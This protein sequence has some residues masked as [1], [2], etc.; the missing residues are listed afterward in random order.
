MG[1]YRYS[2]VGRLQRA[3]CAYYRNSEVTYRLCP[4][5][6]YRIPQ[7][8]LITRELVTCSHS[9]LY[10][11]DQTQ[12]PNNCAD[13]ASA[14]IKTPISASFEKHI[15][16]A[17]YERSHYQRA[18]KK[19]IS[20]LYVPR[21]RCNE[22]FSTLVPYMNYDFLEDAAALSEELQLR[23]GAT[24]DCNSP[25]HLMQLRQ[26]WHQFQHLKANTDVIDAKILKVT[27][28]LKI[29]KKGKAENKPTVPEVVEGINIHDA[30]KDELLLLL[31]KLTYIRKTAVLPLQLFE[32]EL[33]PELLG[34]PNTLSPNT[35]KYT[36]KVERFFSPPLFSFP[37]RSHVQ[38]GY[39]TKG[40]ELSP[41]SLG[42][43]YLHGRLAEVE[44][45]LQD[46]VADTLDVH[47]YLQQ[48][49]P[50]FAKGVSIEGC[51]ME[52]KDTTQKTSTLRLVRN[53]AEEDIA[54]L[55][56]V[57]G[58]SLPSYV[59]YF[60]KKK[61]TN[62]SKFLPQKLYSVGRLYNPPRTFYSSNDEV[63]EMPNTSDIKNVDTKSEIGA[64]G[65]F[66][67]MQTSSVSCFILND[68]ENPITESSIVQEVLRIVRS[69]YDGLELHYRLV[70][71]RAGLLKPH[72]KQAISIQ[73]LT[74]TDVLMTSHQRSNSNN[75]IASDGK[76]TSDII[77]CSK[78]S[79]DEVSDMSGCSIDS[80]E[81][82]YVEVGR[83]SVCGDYISKRLLMTYVKN[84]P[85]VQVEEHN[86][87]ECVYCEV[88]NV[89]K[90][91]AV[92]LEN[93]QTHSGSYSLPNVIEKR[94]VAR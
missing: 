69:I 20:S 49:N 21:H 65:I 55:F 29:L 44:L 91:L 88:L 93:L 14:N 28:R 26:Q 81:A 6:I 37:P 63:A 82:G 54:P 53:S 12:S 85:Q 48:V 36:C 94:M 1:V 73:M 40:L 42:S 74:T 67:S 22:M 56:L 75:S 90:F 32:D 41:T 68:K 9:L 23:D 64:A 33:I 84:A 51:A 45:A 71:L 52:T 60:A 66:S 70:H 57:G 27:K 92:M 50:D 30:I 15:D 3:I 11:Q 8:P 46:Y 59:G 10:R 62:I 31:N 61:V 24:L 87:L 18:E 58:A 13:A 78:I 47:G 2:S 17:N 43:Y 83:V 35:A 16:K 89:S 38:L 79:H 39:L 19:E 76:T 86:F 80:E 34:L 77:D 25:K 4:L 7:K 72:E 5:H